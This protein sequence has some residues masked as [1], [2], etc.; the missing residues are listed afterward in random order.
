MRLREFDLDLPGDVDHRHE[1]RLQTRC[2]T[3]LYERCFPGL[4]VD[5]A[6][7]VLV[8][9]VERVEQ[10]ETRDLLGVF[11][12]QVPFDW[13]G[14]QIAAPLERKKMTLAGLQEG[15]RR[16]VAEK[17]WPSAPFEQAFEGVVAR[18][19]VNDLTWPDRP[20]A[21]PDRRHKA[22]L[23]CVHDMD[24][25]R[26]WL[27]I[28]DKNGREVAR[29]PAFDVLPSDHAFDAKM[30]R[31]EW[32]S[33]D[34]VVLLGKR[35]GKEV[36]SMWLPKTRRTN[37]ASLSD[38]PIVAPRAAVRTR[39]A[40]A[41]TSARRATTTFDDTFW[42][43]IDLLDWDK[44]GDDDAVIEPLVAALS[45]RSVEEIQRFEDTLAEKLRA[46]DTEAHAREIGE[47]AYDGPDSPF[48]PD[49]FLY[50]RSCIVANGRST[51]ERVLTDPNEMLKDLEFEALLYV[52]SKAY[53]RKTGKD[54]TYVPSTSY[55]TFTNDAGWKA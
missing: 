39:H 22:C 52:A 45:G 11:V 50:V 40:V 17:R 33:N 38:E 28:S 23:F 8:E 35:D 1:F 3:R 5:K 18:G 16:V 34:R 9:C 19:Y 43:L 21:S 20:K 24:M 7:K 54:F 30:G 42:S 44:T 14:W 12:T 49:W 27:V 53:E 46:L 25:F 4:A 47:Q 2:I 6:W 41:G 13:A 31:L 15:V 48:S 10:P 55:E 51:F 29:E 26:A 36:K 37:D 32:R